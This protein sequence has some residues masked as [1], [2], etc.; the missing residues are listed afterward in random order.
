MDKYLNVNVEDR[1]IYRK[2]K[3]KKAPAISFIAG[4]SVLGIFFINPNP[5]QGHTEQF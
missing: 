5:N 1:N 4:A 3:K 2:N